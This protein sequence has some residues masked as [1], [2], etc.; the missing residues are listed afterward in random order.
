MEQ[1]RNHETLPVIDREK[2]LIDSQDRELNRLFWTLESDRF[3]LFDVED[4]LI[5]IWQNNPKARPYIAQFVSSQ[6]SSVES[7]LMRNTKTETKENPET[8][9]KLNLFENLT[10]DLQK[11]LS[12]I[13]NSLNSST[14]LSLKAMDSVAGLFTDTIVFNTYNSSFETIKSQAKNILWKIHEVD[15][16]TLT[17]NQKQTYDKLGSSPVDG[18]YLPNIL[19][20]W[21]RKTCIEKNPEFET[22][23]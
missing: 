18:I 7:M 20:L 1:L 8:T 4:T 6:K 12:D 3:S 16:T 23:K 15:V 19:A 5:K 11:S 17:P 13:Q 22:R 21:R 14:S 2:L 9:K 10:E